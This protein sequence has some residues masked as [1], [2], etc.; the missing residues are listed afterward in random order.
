MRSEVFGECRK[1]LLANTGIDATGRLVNAVLADA[2]SASQRCQ[3][4]RPDDASLAVR[5]LANGRI[6]DPAAAILNCK[7]INSGRVT[8]LDRTFALRRALKSS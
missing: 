4:I 7:F 1:P 6:A 2:E 8:I 5:D 3:S